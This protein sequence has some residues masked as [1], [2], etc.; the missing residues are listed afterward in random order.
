MRRRGS[1]PPRRHLG[2]ETRP[3]RAEHRTHG[4]SAPCDRAPRPARTAPRPAAARSTTPIAPARSAT[5]ARARTRR[6]S[7]ASPA[8]HVGSPSG[9]SNADIAISSTAVAA[10]PNNAA[11]PP[12]DS[13][14]RATPCSHDPAS[15]LRSTQRNACEGHHDRGDRW[16]RERTKPLAERWHPAAIEYEVGGIGDRQH[17]ARRVGD[18]RAGEQQRQR[19]DL[20]LLRR[21]IDGGRQHHRSRIVGQEGGG[22]DAG[23]IDQQEEP[24]C[25]SPG[26]DSRGRRDPVEQSLLARGLAEQHHADQE[27][28]DVG[29]L[30]DRAERGDGRQ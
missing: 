24:G 1:C 3:H 18:H 29:A 2:S 27:E 28:I 7:V 9:R 4:R 12:V 15:R 14:S 17:E 10:I 26:V 20:A 30:G 21:G 19:I 8:R 16:R 13:G 5:A 25:R 23:R 11:L 6:A 22:N